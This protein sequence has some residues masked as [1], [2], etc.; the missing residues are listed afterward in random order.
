MLNITNK[1]KKVLNSYLDNV[2][3]LINNDDIERLLLD[4]DDAIIKF[5]MDEEQEITVKGV[6][7]QKIYDQI[8]NQNC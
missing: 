7:M 8:Y 2:E 6:E 4:F 1:Q 3:E 5:G